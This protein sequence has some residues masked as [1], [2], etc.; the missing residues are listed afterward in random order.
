MSGNIIDLDAVR[1]AENDRLQRELADDI[2][3]QSEALADEIYKLGLDQERGAFRYADTL[4]AVEAIGKVDAVLTM[5]APQIADDVRASWA[6]H[7]DIVAAVR[8]HLFVIVVRAYR[9][10]RNERQPRQIVAR[11]DAAMMALSYPM[12]AVEAISPTA[13]STITA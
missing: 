2:A 13:A 3:E 10:A 6:Q 9:R 7:A 8:S 5:L 12:R 11:L 4:D 1:R